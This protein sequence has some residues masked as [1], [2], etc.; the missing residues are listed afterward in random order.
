MLGAVLPGLE[1]AIHDRHPDRAEA[2]AQLARETAGIGGVGVAPSARDA[3]A[4]ADVVVTA[5]SFASPSDRQP[6]TA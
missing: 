3:T 1:L 2:L 6:M 4:E 5:A